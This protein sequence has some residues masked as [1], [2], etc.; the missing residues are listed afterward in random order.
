MNHVNA[1]RVRIEDILRRI[2]IRP[3]HSTVSDDDIGAVIIVRKPRASQ[4]KLVAFDAGDKVG[5]NERHALLKRF[6]PFVLLGRRDNDVHA[7]PGGSKG[8][9]EFSIEG[10]DAPSMGAPLVG[11]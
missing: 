3:Q 1:L 8:D 6:V 9:S 5:C 10:G 7:T 2:G 11:D 4:Q